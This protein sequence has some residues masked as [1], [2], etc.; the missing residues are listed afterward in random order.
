VLSKV[1]KGADKVT[2]DWRKLHN[3]NLH[4]LHSSTNIIRVIISRKIICVGHVAHIGEERKRKEG[5][6]LYK[7]DVDGRIILN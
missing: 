3:E 2:R 1:E 6:H 7:V 4:D 5:D